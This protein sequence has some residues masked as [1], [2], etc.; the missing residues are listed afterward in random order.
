MRM[1]RSM[2]QR[3]NAGWRK[4]ET[5]E[6]TCRPVASSGAIFEC[7]NLGAAPPLLFR[8]VRVMYCPTSAL[9]CAQRLYLTLATQPLPCNDNRQYRLAQQ[10]VIQACVP[11]LANEHNGTSG[12]AGMVGRVGVVARLFAYHLGGPGPIRGWVALPDFRVWESCRTMPLVGG[13]SR[14]SPF[15]TAL[16][17]RRCSI[18]ASL[19]PASAL[20]TSGRRTAFRRNERAGNTGD[21]RENSLTSGIVRDDSHM[22]KYGS[23]SEKGMASQLCC[24]Q[25]RNDAGSSSDGAVEFSLMWNNKR[26]LHVSTSAGLISNGLASRGHDSSRGQLTSSP[27]RKRGTPAPI[28]NVCEQDGDCEPSSVYRLSTVVDFNVTLTTLP[29][30]REWREDSRVQKLNRDDDEGE[31]RRVWSSAGMQGRVKRDITE[32]KSRPVTSFGTYS[33]VRKSRRDPAGNRSRL[34]EEGG[35]R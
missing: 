23:Q 6:K 15:P 19:N 31:V 26:N 30:P 11:G 33:H 4:R 24:N 16:S 13:F 25:W 18:L 5:P 7:K 1:K 28:N 20:K 21:P 3:L 2:E 32:K 8:K 17:F 10:L 35:S 29:A 14:G 12:Q 22:R 9:L 34:D 27:T